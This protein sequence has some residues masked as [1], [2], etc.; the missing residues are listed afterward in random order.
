MSFALMQHGRLRANRTGG[1]GGAQ[2][3]PLFPVQLVCH[4]MSPCSQQTNGA[5]DLSNAKAALLFAVSLRPRLF[6]A[7]S[8]AAPGGSDGQSAGRGNLRWEQWDRAPV[9]SSRGGG[10]Q[11][12]S[13]G[14]GRK[15]LAGWIRRGVPVATPADA[16]ARVRYSALHSP[17]TLAVHLVRSPPV[18]LRSFAAT[19]ERR[20]AARHRRPPHPPVS[21]LQLTKSARIQAANRALTAVR[22][23]AIRVI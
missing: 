9:Q 16:D 13:S 8:M 23:R 5:R 7:R 6:T 20:P 18:A 22:V 3:G 4:P 12:S 17:H 19:S 11:G 15:V 21:P 10:T 2:T 14:D 1:R